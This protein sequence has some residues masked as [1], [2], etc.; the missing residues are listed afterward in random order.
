MRLDGTI[1][2]STARSEAVPSHRTA[3]RPGCAKPNVEELA[4][5]TR[6]TVTGGVCPFVGTQLCSPLR[7]SYDMSI[8]GRRKGLMDFAERNHASGERSPAKHAHGTR[9]EEADPN[10]NWSEVR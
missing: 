8:Y 10:Q 3:L 2:T 6:L 4:T 1:R 7:Y 9:A 5:R